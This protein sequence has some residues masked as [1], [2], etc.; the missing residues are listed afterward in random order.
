MDTIHTCSIPSA[1]NSVDLASV[2]NFHRRDAAVKDL[3]SEPDTSCTDIDLK[4][5][6]FGTTLAT[7]FM[8]HNPGGKGG[9]I[10]FT[11]S[12]IGI[13]PCQTFLEYCAA[14]A[15]THRWVKTVSPSSSSRKTSL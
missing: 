13:Y 3:C 8:R 7:H 15:A 9:K 5:T 6:I 12:V 2:Y 1:T 11:G 10:L 4:D 14:K